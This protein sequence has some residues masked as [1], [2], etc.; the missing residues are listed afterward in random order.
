MNI[1][2]LHLSAPYLYCST[3]NAYLEIDK[4][5]EANLQASNLTCLP[6]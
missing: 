2:I 4:G 3:L 5:S 6:T 1:S